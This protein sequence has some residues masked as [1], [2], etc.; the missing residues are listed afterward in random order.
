MLS[1]IRYSQ[2]PQ[3]MFRIYTRALSVERQIVNNCKTEKY[4]RQTIW[5]L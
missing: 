3:E 1:G 4:N 5:F 2:A